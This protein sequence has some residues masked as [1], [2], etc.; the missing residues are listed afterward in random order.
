MVTFDDLATPNSTGGVPWG[1]VPSSYAGLTWEGWEVSTAAGYRD[2]FGNTYAIPSPPN[3]AYN[4][5][6]TMSVSTSGTVFDFVGAEVSTWAYGNGFASYSS[7]TLTAE[8]YLGESLVG[9]VTVNLASDRF[10]SL[11]ANFLGIDRVIFR[12]DGVN[13]HW[14]TLDNFQYTPVPEP[15]EYGAL[16]VLGLIGYGLYEHFGRARARRSKV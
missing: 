13:G 11:Q 6:G 2:N 5:D 7:R 3:F 8:G 12:N 4:T 16:A 9:S 1:P 15:C 10:E 14:W